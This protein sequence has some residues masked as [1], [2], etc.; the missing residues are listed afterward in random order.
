MRISTNYLLWKTSIIELQNALI[1][2]TTFKISNM[3][4]EIKKF[5]KQIGVTLFKNIKLNF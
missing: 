5:V 3:D 4:K 1:Q 2:E